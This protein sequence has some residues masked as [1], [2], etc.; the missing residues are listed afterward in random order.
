ML[1]TFEP[2]PDFRASAQE[3]L[4]YLHRC[5]GFSLWMVKRTE[6]NDWIVLQSEDHGYNVKKGGR[7]AR[8]GRGRPM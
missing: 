5:Y 2:F 8:S 4:Q 7:M 3:V 6:G 1:S